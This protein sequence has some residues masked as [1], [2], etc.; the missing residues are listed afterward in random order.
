MLFESRRLAAIDLHRER[1][2]Y[3]EADP[4]I[5]PKEGFAELRE[6]TARWW[7]CTGDPVSGAV[8]R[9]LDQRLP[10]GKLHVDDSGMVLLSKK[11]L[12]ARDG[13][14]FEP[15]AVDIQ[16]HSAVVT[17]DHV[18]GAL[19]TGD[20][21]VR[22]ARATGAVERI[23]LRGWNDSASALA[24]DEHR[25][26]WAASQASGGLALMVASHAALARPTRIPL[27]IPVSG[28]RLFAGARRIVAETRALHVLDGDGIRVV[29]HVPSALRMWT[30]TPRWVV[31]VRGHSSLGE[32]RTEHYFGG[33]A[34]FDDRVELIY[35]TPPH[36][37]V[38]PFGMHEGCDVLWVGL[39][40]DTIVFLERGANVDRVMTIPFDAPVVS[41]TS[42]VEHDDEH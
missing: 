41:R 33:V 2:Y 16:A 25:L 27:E 12:L 4:A 1:I 40:G 19:A 18:I 11:T 36:E 17:C 29:K 32:S 14:P 35:A 34:R 5:A 37:R 7:L 26:V 3:L 8:Q 13:A 42:R 38:G 22:I 9:V 20:G 10:G 39:H 30:R 15:A 21:I 23:T 28:V 31:A 24:A 6:P